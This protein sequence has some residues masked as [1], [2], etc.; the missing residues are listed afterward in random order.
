L[1]VVLVKEM[2]V[3]KRL[4]CITNRDFPFTLDIIYHDPHVDNY[5]IPG[6][7]HSITSCALYENTSEM[8]FR[9]KTH[10]DAIFELN[11]IKEKKEGVNKYL[12]SVN[13]DIY[14]FIELHSHKRP[15]NP[16]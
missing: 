9:F 3:R 2:N 14:K 6:A 10:E 13:V 5:F 4:F 16:Q 11:R 7:N 1:D 15:C 12:E 8:T